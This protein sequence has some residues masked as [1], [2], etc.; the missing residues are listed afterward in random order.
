MIFQTLDDKN[1]CVGVFYNDQLLF[2]NIQNLNLS[3]T[4]S[5]SQ[6]LKN[7]DIE[8]A[9]LYCNGKSIDE[10]CPESLN[11]DW[12]RVN[13]ILK[14]HINACLESKIS[15]KENCFYNLVPKR[16]LI[17]YCILKNKITEHVLQNY[18]KPKEYNFIKRFNELLTDIKFR[19]LNIK[20]D[21]I[22]NLLYKEGTNNF[23]K[24]IA[25][26]NNYINYNM[27]NSIT[28]RLTIKKDSFPILT[29]QKQHRNILLPQNDWFIS[30][31]MNA[32]E[33][34]IALALMG[35]SQPEGDF[36]EWSVSNIYNKELDRAGAKETTTSWLYN[37]NSKNANKYDSNL[38]NVFDK[39]KLK[40]NY[41]IDGCV[42]TPYNRQIVSDEYH[43]IS[44][45][46]QSTFIDLFHRQ[47]IKVDD[48]LQNK[49]S[50]ISFM[51]HD[52]LVLDVTEEEKKNII[53]ITKILQDTPYGIF[54]VNIKAGKNFGEMKKLNLKVK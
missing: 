54:P 52:E 37:S 29:F 21:N 32:A 15:L 11:N 42:Q 20:L 39:E 27:F 41:W 13:S 1:T 25:N 7:S 8:Y 12:S 19:N 14:S 45:L 38:S 43:S 26:K 5:Y 34:R 49:K 4:W 3:K 48:Y 17:E 50:F 47:V 2:N 10:V 33:L 40:N 31:D 9:N 35:L 51:I 44:Y 53:D 22:H 18:N 36:H 30:F 23:Y 6:F 24:K 16:F 28:G 46:N